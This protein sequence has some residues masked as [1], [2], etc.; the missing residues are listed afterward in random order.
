MKFPLSPYTKAWLSLLIVALLSTTCLL[1]L[2]PSTSAQ[3]KS[4]P[5]KKGEP[6][7][8]QQDPLIKINTNLVQVDVVVKDDAGQ[9]VTDLRAE[10]FEIV[11]NG[12]AHPV[13][14]C[15]YTALTTE[16]PAST[17][18]L[19][20][21]LAKNE[22]GR[23]IVFVVSNQIIDLNIVINTLTFGRIRSITNAP[24]VSLDAQSVGNFLD[25][26]IEKQMGPRDLVA[27]LNAERDLG[28]LSRFTNNRELLQAAS[29]EIRRQVA[30]V[31]RTSL[32]S[33]N[34]QLSSAPVVSQ[35]LVTLDLLSNAIERTQNLPGRKIIVLAMRGLL[36]NSRLPG[37]DRVQDRLR[38][39][40]A[41]ANQAHI[42]IYTLSPSGLGLRGGGLQDLDSLVA[43]AT[44]TGGRAIY[45]TNDIG[46][47]FAEILKENQGYYLL[48]YDPGEGKPMAPHKIK[49]RVKRPG[50]QAQSRAVAYAANVTSGANA[51]NVISATAEST[52][53][54]SLAEALS[55]PFAL[56]DIGIG[57]TPL[58]LSSDG[59]E[60]HILSFLKID[61]TGA[62]TEMAADGKQTLKLEIALQITG[63]DGKL[64]KEEAKGKAFT[65]T[66]AE[67]ERLK[68]Q[69]LSYGFNFPVTSPGYYQ[70]TAAVRDPRSGRVGNA[71]RMVKVAELNRQ[72][73]ATSSLALSS[74]E[75]RLP[76]IAN[77]RAEGEPFSP[78][79]SYTRSETVRYQCYVYHARQD[80]TQ[81]SRLQA[82]VIIKRGSEVIARGE[83]R[84]V[85]QPSGPVLPVTGEWRLAD[86][87]PGIYTLEL[88]IEDLLHKDSKLTASAPLEVK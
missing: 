85:T 11:E 57:L 18:T 20:G 86:L 50:L 73:L 62:A 19:D 84:V 78:K 33:F 12:R 46:F 8:I 81:S 65:L 82:Q 55:T 7:S 16:L 2:L 15:S 21:R 5:Q 32:T 1:N 10:D 4:P 28:L 67:F 71:S 56:R 59:K 22:L 36:F 40:T 23:T 44:E 26:F 17:A 58:F 38:K 14:Y 61:P 83:P 66:P 34:G 60:S 53:H 74:P 47:G 79:Q 87:A 9:I 51:A 41:Q 6:A 25:Q 63:P 77:A 27:I 35:N 30:E 48:G 54:I 29:E 69:G 49:V 70:V 37:S 80:N 52:E 13:E 39:L 64:I 88:V 3:Q 42:A 72:I 31:P 45:N 24:N 75:K 68:Q 76:P 43:L